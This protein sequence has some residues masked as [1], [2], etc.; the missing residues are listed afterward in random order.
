MERQLLKVCRN[1]LGACCGL[2]KP[3][4]QFHNWKNG[5]YGKN[6]RCKECVLRYQRKYSKRKI[7]KERQKRYQQSPKG[8]A[9]MAATS[10]R[11]RAAKRKAVPK[12][13]SKEHKR[14]IK[15]LFRKRNILNQLLGRVGY[16]V[17]HIVPLVSDKVCG[18]EVPWNMRILEA[19]KNIEKSNKIFS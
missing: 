4:D 13:L 1:R 9:I 18:L 3:L 14:Q 5:Q 7:F 10:S 19:D 15:A 8:K 12:W 11:R 17:D 6:S 16:H 2:L